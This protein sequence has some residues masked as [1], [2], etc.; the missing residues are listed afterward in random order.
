MSQGRIRYSANDEDRLEAF[1]CVCVGG[2]VA[3]NEMVW[4]GAGGGERTQM[5]IRTAVRTCTASSRLKVS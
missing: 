1:G 3:D 5:T 2:V 4:G